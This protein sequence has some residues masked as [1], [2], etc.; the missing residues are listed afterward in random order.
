MPKTTTP[1]GATRYQVLPPLDPETYAALKANIALNG[2]LVPV[3]RD[4]DGNVLD[5]FARARSPRN[6]VI[7]PR[8]RP[9]GAFRDG[10][11]IAQSCLETARRQLDQAGKRVVI[12]D[13]LREN[14]ARSNRWIAKSLG[15]EPQTVSRCPADA[16]INSAESASWIAPW[17][18]MGSIAPLPG[19]CRGGAKATAEPRQFID[20]RDEK[21][22][23]RTAG[24]SVSASGELSN[25]IGNRSAERRRRPGRN[26]RASGGG[27]SR[28]IRR[29]SAAIC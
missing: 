15:V 2:I 9:G 25:G 22:I 17:G 11:A 14:P 20:L 18:Q 23:L 10:E 27:W 24:V 16:R 21:A 1:R 7:S 12:A 8:G 19:D 5:G 6:S 29:L 3:V 28:V 13:Q 26:S 4:E